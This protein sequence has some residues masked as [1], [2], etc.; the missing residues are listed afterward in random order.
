MDTPLNE[1]DRYHVTHFARQACDWF[2]L[3]DMVR[4]TAAPRVARL[5]IGDR[6]E[7]IF[8]LHRMSDFAEYVLPFKRQ[9]DRIT[10]FEDA[11]AE[12]IFEA[13]VVVPE[14]QS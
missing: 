1:A 3:F 13:L 8:A 12:A 10:A 7:I 6:L 4:P 9:D 11:V 2:R 14:V 5:N